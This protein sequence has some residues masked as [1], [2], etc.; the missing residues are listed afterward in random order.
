MLPHKKIEIF[1]AH[2]PPSSLDATPQITRTH[3]HAVLA[4]ATL[5][6]VKKVADS[7]QEGNKTKKLV[8]R[9][10]SSSKMRPVGGLWRVELSCEKGRPARRHKGR[11]GEAY[12]RWVRC[13]Y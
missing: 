5:I 4:E 1:D 9:R 6:T 11:R 3:R 10:G 13:L 12:V 8:H 7:M 2:G